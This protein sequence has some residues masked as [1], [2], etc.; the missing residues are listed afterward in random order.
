MKHQWRFEWN[1]HQI[2]IDSNWAA[3]SHL[4][5]DNELK[6]SNRAL[7]GL[8]AKQVLCWDALRVEIDYKMFWA[9]V[10]VT[11]GDEV[12]FQKRPRGW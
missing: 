7:F 4:F 10:M 6:D 12:I 3:G 5:V 1:Q 2:R 8:P 9:E 11:A